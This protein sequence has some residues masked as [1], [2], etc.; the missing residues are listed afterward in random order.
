VTETL[1][2]VRFC[3]CPPMDDPN[4][5]AQHEAACAHAAFVEQLAAL[6][7]MPLAF[8]FR[9]PSTPS[10]GCYEASFGWVH[11]RPACRCPSRT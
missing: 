9:A 4:D 11:V 3:W 10:D 6:H 5:P 8:P 2:G 1:D 7:A